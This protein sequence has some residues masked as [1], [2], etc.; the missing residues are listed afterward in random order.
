[1]LGDAGDVDYP[2]FLLN[3]RVPAA[4]AAYDSKPGTPLRIRFINVGADT[5]FRVALGGHR[6]TVT[7]TDGYPVNQVDTDAPLIGMG[8]RHDVLITL[9]DG[10]LPFGGS[11]RGQGR[12]GARPR[13]VA[14]SRTRFQ[15]LAGE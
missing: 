7:H 10:V 2:C 15:G 14:V 3:G 9:A 1:M 13:T 8:E 4:P 12:R 6:M 11:G 5:A